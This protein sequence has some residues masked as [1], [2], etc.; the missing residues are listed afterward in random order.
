MIE[1]KD[2]SI[3]YQVAGELENETSANENAL[4]YFE[5][6]LVNIKDTDLLIWKTKI[7][8]E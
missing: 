7:M 3:A 6:E 4:I 1:E 5:K 8:K 2:F